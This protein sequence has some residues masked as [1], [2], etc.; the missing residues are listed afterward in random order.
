MMTPEEGVDTPGHSHE[1]SRTDGDEDDITKQKASHGE[2]VVNGSSRKTEGEQGELFE[3][4]VHSALSNA[5][6]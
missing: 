2:I 4:V 3:S 5:N 6:V 1:K